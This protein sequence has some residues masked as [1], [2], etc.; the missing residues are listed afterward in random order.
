MGSIQ[1]VH[2]ELFDKQLYGIKSFF[3]ND[4]SFFG[5]KSS[6]IDYPY[7]FDPWCCYGYDLF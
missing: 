2:N 7:I 4:T 6:R 1:V 5:K 3:L